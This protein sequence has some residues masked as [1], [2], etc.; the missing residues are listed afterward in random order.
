MDLD[1]FRVPLA[2]P[3]AATDVDWLE[4]CAS[5]DPLPAADA[6]WLPAVTA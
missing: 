1:Q 2:V 4:C 6:P 3:A 5:S